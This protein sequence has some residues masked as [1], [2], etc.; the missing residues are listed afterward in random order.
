MLILSLLTALFLLIFFFVIIRTLVGL[1]LAIIIALVAGLIAESL[2]GKKR[3]NPIFSIIVG[4]IGAIVG[5]M[6]ARALSLPLLFTIEGLP[7]IWTI[8][9]ATIVVVVWQSVRPEAS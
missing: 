9:G 8:V 3:R 4:F 1:A 6:I 2:V 7:V 5:T